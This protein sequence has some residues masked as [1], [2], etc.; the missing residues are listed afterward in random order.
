[1]KNKKTKKTELPP[2]QTSK[3][4]SKLRT[5][6]L[7]GM[8]NEDTPPALV[9]QMHE[10]YK[11]YPFY[12]FKP[13]LKNLLAA[14]AKRKD[15]AK[16]DEIAL[17]IFLKNKPAA[18]NPRPYPEWHRSVADALLKEDITAKRHL[19]MKPS[20]LRQSRPEYMVYSLKVFRDHARDEVR[21]R[22]GRS[23]WLAQAALKKDAK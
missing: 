11:V 6:I 21:K 14:I 23:Y 15:A 13:N 19:Q 1:M 9:Y 4:K 5:D 16:E 17:T 2:W 20:M 10:E 8:V 18:V 12:R 22:N 3:A 7:K